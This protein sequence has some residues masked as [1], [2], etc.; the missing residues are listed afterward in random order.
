M[1]DDNRSPSLYIPSVFERM[2]AS[3]SLLYGQTGATDL[4][5]LLVNSSYYL[6][7]GYNYDNWN[8]GTYGIAAHF[9]VPR[10]IYL[11]LF[12]RL[13]EIED[14]IRNRL[15][16]LEVVENEYIAAVFLEQDKEEPLDNWRELSGVL[17]HNSPLSH[18]SNQGDIDR[19][20][21][22]N[23]LRVFLSH[24]SE[25]KVE[26]SNLKEVFKKYGVSC[27][28]AHEDIE[29]SR[30][31]QMEIEKALFS[32]HV[33]V[34]LMTD[35]FHD[36]AWTDQEIGIAIGRSIPVFSIRLGKDPY[37]F[38]G[39]YQAISG[40]GKLPAQLVEEIIDKFYSNA[41]LR[42]IA[43]DS[44]VSRFETCRTYIQAN[45][46]FKLI[47]KHANHLTDDHTHRIIKASKAN[48]A[49]VESY[50]VK[51][52]LPTFLELKGISG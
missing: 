20:W 8:G 10:E 21:G 14:D 41:V 18:N 24:K 22:R 36:S 47:I 29:P 25:Y 3:L 2:V 51:N 5:R 49:A 4:Q 15:N 1:S 43:A 44:L 32:A 31:W 35:Q 45:E 33:L 37:G 38:I 7:E 26:T 27:F 19:L 11:A 28:V 52:K 46:I 34:A 6:D 16:R 13:S 23:H 42:E 48:P 50:V 12:D 30:E 40:Y 39:K 17:V 9:Q